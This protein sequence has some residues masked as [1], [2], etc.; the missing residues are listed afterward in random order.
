MKHPEYSLSQI[1]EGIGR[2]VQMLSQEG[3]WQRLQQGI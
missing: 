1:K 3:R 2:K